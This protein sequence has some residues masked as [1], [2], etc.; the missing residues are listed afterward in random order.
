MRIGILFLLWILAVPQ[1]L[2]AHEIRPGYLQIIETSSQSLEITW[3]QP[4]MGAYGLP[5]HPS[6]SSG[7][8]NDSLAQISCSESYLIKRWIIPH[9]IASLD[10]QTIIIGGL[11]NT[12]TD[13]LILVKGIGDLSYTYLLK[14]IQPF[15]KMNLS[16][17]QAPPV[18][19]YIRLGI[20]HIWTG[21][22]H[23][24][25]VFG[26][27]LLVQKKFNLLWTITAFTVA[28]SLTLALATFNI[29]RVSSTFTEAAIAMSIVFLAVEI[30]HQYQGKKGLMST[31]PWA[32][33]FFFGLL[34]GLGFAGALQDVGLPPNDIHLAL[35]LFNTGVEFGQLLFVMAA[36]IV[37]T[38]IK[39]IQIPFPKWAHQIPAY[40]IGA[41]AMFWLLERLSPL[42]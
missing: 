3:K 26:L 8:L 9:G 23:L 13:V 30:V 33:S 37:I 41:F 22:D 17:P 24:L 27:M 34:H 2:K 10:Q 18:W 31:Y 29:I 35:F 14:P 40:I 42:L 32:V 5:L 15:V 38:C 25:F 6:M 19:Q 28:H 21:F 1:M 36:L 16:K 4:V 12:M 11:E 7:W 39:R 20:H